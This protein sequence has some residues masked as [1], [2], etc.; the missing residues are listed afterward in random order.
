M[1][2]YLTIITRCMSTVFYDKPRLLLRISFLIL[3]RE[4]KWGQQYLDLSLYTF[5]RQEVEDIL[6]CAILFRFSLKLLRQVGYAG[7]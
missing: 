1:I 3:N 6:S 2:I 4:E 5:T 7:R